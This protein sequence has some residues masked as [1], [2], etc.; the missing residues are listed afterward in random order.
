MRKPGVAKPDEHFNTFWQAFPRRV[1]KADAL[2]AWGQINPTPELVDTMLDALQW[3]TRQP[4]WVK[5]GGAYVP[6]P[7]S[8][9]RGRRWEDEPFST[10]SPVGRRQKVPDDEPL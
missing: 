3:Q 9:L 10:I 5:D 2:K 8:W 4:G 6:Y 1:A 7:A